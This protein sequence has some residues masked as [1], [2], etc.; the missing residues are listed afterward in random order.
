M[1]MKFNLYQENSVKEY[2][3]V[4]PIDEKVYSYVLEND[5]YSGRKPATN[6]TLLKRLPFDNLSFPVKNILEV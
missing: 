6:G 1:N 3:I 5:K 2:W 4:K